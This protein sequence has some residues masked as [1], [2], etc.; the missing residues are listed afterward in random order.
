MP[1][2]KIKS[3]DE[4]VASNGVHMGGGKERRK[5]EPFEVLE[6][7]EDVME[8][9]RSLLDILWETG[10][11][12][13]TLDPPTRPLDYES[14]RE[15][16]LCSPTFKPRGPDEQIEQDKARAAVAK[17]MSPQVVPEDMG[18]PAT[19]S[20]PEPEAEDPPAEEVRRNRRAERRAALEQA[21][22]SE[23]LSR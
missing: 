11:L 3:L 12:E 18:S 4:R 14:Y 5:L 8:G 20:Q 17:R 2:V 1:R 7:G 6:I 15:G 23:A 9:D 22:R 21:R 10:K 19:E 16:R 13:L